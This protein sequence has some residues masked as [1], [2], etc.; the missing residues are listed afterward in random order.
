[1]GGDGADI[2]NAGTGVDHLTG[3][4]AMD[5]FVFTDNQNIGIITDFVNG[6]DVI[7]LSGHS[8]YSSFA[9]VMANSATFG[10][11]IIIYNGDDDVIAI[12][13]FTLGDLSADDFIF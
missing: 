7:D 10:G 5:T 8:A 11:A 6:I 1:M 13:N 12:Q 2:I 3:G 9:D 4:M